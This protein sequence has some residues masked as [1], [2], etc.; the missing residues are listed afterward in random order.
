MFHTRVKL[1][2]FS[3]Y[4]FLPIR[5]RYCIITTLRIKYIFLMKNSVRIHTVQHQ[6]R[7]KTSEILKSGVLFSGFL[8]Q[9]SIYINCD[10]FFVIH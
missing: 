5:N 4:F 1:N 6:L 7:Y 2:Q 10:I 8:Y 9:H 3:L